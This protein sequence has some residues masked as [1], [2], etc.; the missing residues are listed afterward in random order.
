MMLLVKRRLQAWAS[1]WQVPKTLTRC[2]ST[3]LSPFF[4]V[5]TLPHDTKDA[6]L[7][8]LGQAT[9]IRELTRPRPVECPEPPVPAAL[10]LVSPRHTSW[11]SDVDFMAALVRQLRRMSIVHGD[12]PTKFHLL[13]AV[14]DALPG[15]PPDGVPQE[16]LAFATDHAHYLL[17]GLWDDTHPSLP[18]TVAS[19][20]NFVARTKVVTH[21]GRTDLIVTLPLANTLFVTGR[22]TTLLASEWHI[23]STHD[24]QPKVELSKSAQKRMQ[25]VELGPSETRLRCTLHP[26]THPRIVADALGNIISK[27]KIE[28][29]LSPA[30]E[31]LQRELPI[32]LQ[33]REKHPSGEKTP[34]PVAV[35]ALVIPKQHV[36]G[37]WND[38]IMASYGRVL[39]TPQISPGTTSVGPNISPGTTR[40]GTL[41]Q[42][43]CRLVRVCE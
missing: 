37:P 12:D 31:E 30:S 40:V 29:K 1:V 27:I 38:V 19:S 14:V 32:W 28:G 9:L 3:S 43:G 17:P 21:V 25:S 2:S 36:E 8:L 18:D 16:G 15:I 35:W 24:H 6:I 11:L 23:D 41:V 10:M 13:A 22:R 33:N 42:R 20:L 7:G 4:S 5:P 26:L 34:G 39:S